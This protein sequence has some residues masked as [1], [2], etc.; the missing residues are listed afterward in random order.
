ME[1][2][3]SND[4]FFSIEI[5]EHDGELAPFSGVLCLRFDLGGG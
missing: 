4:G 1:I 5:G 3:A 2:L